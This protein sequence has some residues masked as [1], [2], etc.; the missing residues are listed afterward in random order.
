MQG[1]QYDPNG[2]RIKCNFNT[3]NAK[4]IMKCTGFSLVKERIQCTRKQLAK[5]DSAILVSKDKLNNT[6][7]HDDLK[8][9]ERMVKR[10]TELIFIKCKSKQL[11]KFKK[12]KKTTMNQTN[13]YVQHHVNVVNL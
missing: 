1:Q 9:C 2:L 12:L 11:T 13:N 6:L 8:T 7:I 5:I 10:S 4:R 3:I